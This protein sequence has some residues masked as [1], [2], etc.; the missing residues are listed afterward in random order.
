VLKK[1]EAAVA[2]GSEADARR[3]EIS[4]AK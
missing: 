4:S 2:G 3:V 1:P